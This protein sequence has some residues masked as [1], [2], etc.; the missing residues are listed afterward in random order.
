VRRALTL[1]CA[2]LSLA[3]GSQAD[4]RES[5]LP[6]SSGDADRFDAKWA[7]VV[8]RR[9]AAPSRR[10]NS[11]QTI[12]TEPEVNAYLRYRATA[13]LPVGVVDPYVFAL[14]AGR[15]SV[16]ATV[17]LDAVR[18]SRAR[19]WFDMAR[20]LRGRVPVTA[21]G[22]LRSQDGVF[23]LELESAT[24]AGFAI[25]K[26]LLQ[27]LVTFYSRTAANP[28]GFELDAPFVL[29]GGIRDILVRPGQ[30]VIIQ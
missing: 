13:E 30:A 27:E 26:P 29:P 15:L 12:I 22:V 9:P 21:V 19:D 5:R 17:D 2:C 7:S 16:V 20:L 28:R 3:A 18:L 6:F 10:R 14:G 23:R 1:I 11:I 4:H 25:P 8:S 24:A